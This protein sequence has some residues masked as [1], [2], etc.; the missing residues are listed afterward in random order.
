MQTVT[1]TLSP[2]GSINNPSLL[3]QQGVPG[4]PS[5]I[6]TRLMGKEGGMAEEIKVYEVFNN[7]V[8]KEDFA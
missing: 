1:G 5:Q 8:M 7:E 2:Q 3:V 6:S 4:N